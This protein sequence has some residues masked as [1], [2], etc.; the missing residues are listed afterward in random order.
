[1]AGNKSISQSEAHPVRRLDKDLL[2]KLLAYGSILLAVVFLFR[3]IERYLSIY[4]QILIG[5]VFLSVISICYRFKLFEKAPYRFVIILT[6]AFITL[7]Y[8]IW[9]TTE[10]LLYTGVYDLIG[11]TLLYLAEC[12][13]VTIHFLGLFINLWP[14]ENRP[15]PLLPK[16]AEGLPT[17]D[18]LIPTYTE[19]ADI[20]RITVIAATQIDYPKEKL[21]IHILD[22]GGTEARRNNPKI[23][24][25]AWERYYKLKAMAGELGVNYVTREGNAHAKAGNINHALKVTSAE[26]VLILDCDHVPTSDI[27]KNTVGWFLADKKLFLV[28]TPHFFINPTPI[29]KNLVSFSNVSG[30]ND[31]FYRVIHL[32]LDSWNASYFCGSAALLRRSCLDATGGICGETITEDAETSFTMH[33]MGYNSVYI[34]RP[35][36]CGLSPETFDAY[37]IQR[38][39]WA[40]GMIQLFILKNPLFE[41]GLT[42]PQRLCYFNACFFWF[43]GVSRFIFYIAPAAFL[44]VG[45]KVYHA[46]LLQVLAFCL[47]HVL[48]V[49]FIMDFLYGKVRR[50]FF[51][52][53]YESVQALFLIPAVF[54]VI[55][56][57]RR[58]T[59]KITPKGSTLKSDYLNP[60]ASTFLLVVIIN[61]AAM[62]LAVYKWIHYP[63]FRDVIYLTASWCL[64]N[65][66]LALVSL[67][68]FWETKQ[69]RAYHR[70]KASGRIRVFFHRMGKAFDG[71]IMDISLTGIRIRL[72]LP[73]D[74]KQEEDIVLHA[75]D[76]YGEAYEFKARIHRPIKQGAEVLCGT[77]FTLGKDDYARAVKFVYG[78]SHRWAEIWA[79]K[80]NAASTASLLFYFMRMGVKGLKDSSVIAS[81]ITISAVRKYPYAWLVAGMRKAHPKAN[82]I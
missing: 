28:Q 52:E 23:T 58:P 72:K 60:M 45:L 27:L 3:F 43:F 11:L 44:I 47:P 21:R 33:S 4:Y 35:M 79:E 22:D 30:E 15:V 12:Y 14:L 59:F 17:I 70:I 29:E 25:D 18:I 49:Y 66:I 8:F 65:I 2:F 31:M 82:Q 69:V 78:D 24:K 74:V 16:D 50:P 76:G 32:G 51:S 81:R 9:R 56:N 77:E 40:Q 19:S 46:S 57:P 36:V 13:T 7:R 37:I 55:M 73:F 71:E 53:L 61:M 20:V 54:S 34:N 64:F 5:G 48:S 75:N 80:A 42:I 26:L 38:T 10:T 41:R 6:G 68:A 62:P 1:M 67:G 39:R 63:T